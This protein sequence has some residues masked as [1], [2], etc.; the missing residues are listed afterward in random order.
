MYSLSG[1]TG[2]ATMQ[3]LMIRYPLSREAR[4]SH[5]RSSSFAHKTAAENRIAWRISCHTQWRVRLLLLCVALGVPRILPAPA[6][7][8]GE[9]PAI[10]SATIGIGLDPTT[11][12]PARIETR[13]GSSKRQWLAGPVRLTVRNEVTSSKASLASDSEDVWQH[14]GESLAGSANLVGLPLK[15][16]QQWSLRSNA[17]AWEI[18]FRG[19]A[20]RAGHTVTIELPIL[21]KDSKVFTPT[22]RGVMEVAAYPTRR[23]PM[24]AHSDWQLG[25]W[26]WRSRPS[27]PRPGCVCR[28]LGAWR[29]FRPRRPTSTPRTHSQQ[30]TGKN[31]SAREV[32]GSR[33]LSATPRKMVFA[34]KSSTAKSSGGPR[35]WVS[36]PESLSIRVSPMRNPR[37]GSPTTA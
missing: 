1:R 10:E 32:R 37:V 9:D 19:D 24:G 7:C 18:D 20:T 17:V 26:A 14:S 29:T 22:E 5:A 11:G 16:V 8:R 34:W 4:C 27:Q 21:G 15:A 36:T 30:D 12:M 28:W 2:E 35:R 33:G 31:V 13:L 25:N 3:H 6:V 23:V